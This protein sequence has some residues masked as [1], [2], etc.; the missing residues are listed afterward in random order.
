[1]SP[2]NITGNLSEAVFEQGRQNGNKGY[3]LQSYS[4][5]ITF[6]LQEVFA[7]TEEVQL[8]ILLDKRTLLLTRGGISK[9]MA[10]I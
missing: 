9:L 7:L 4:K 6:V 1:M 2:R 8:I 5:T 10:F 3:V